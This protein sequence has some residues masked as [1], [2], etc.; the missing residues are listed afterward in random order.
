M[1]DTQKL[2]LAEDIFDQLHN[3]KEVT[4]RKGRRDIALGEIGFESTQWARQARG[5][6][7]QVTY[8]RLSGVSEE[9]CKRDGF[10]NWLELM[11][12]M[13]RFYPDIK[14]SDEVTIIQFELLEI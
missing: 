2:M 8:L 3:G 5:E 14:A 10:E 4:I 11:K 1:S 7:V 6:V 13:Q 12:T 9:D